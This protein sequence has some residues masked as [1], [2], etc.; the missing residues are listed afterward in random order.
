MSEIE[1]NGIRLYV[2]EHGSGAPILCIHGTGSSSLLW[3]EA[4]AELG[5]RGRAIVYDRR[6]FGR[7]ERPDPLVMDVHLHADDAAAL[8]DALGAGPAV[9]VGRSQGGEIAVDLALRYPER[10]RALALLEGG[11]L[12]LGEGLRRWVALLRERILV[13]AAADPETVGETMLREVVGDEGWEA[14]PAPVRDVFTAN[15]P[16]IVAEEL[17]GLLDVSAEQLGTIAHPTLIVGG[18]GSLPEFAEVTRL[19]AAAMPTATVAWVDGDH[20]IDPAHPAVLRFVDDVLQRESS[21][22]SLRSSSR[23]SASS[24]ASSSARP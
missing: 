6:G 2:E 22:T 5:K 4:G 24:P 10:V 15:G 19:T 14:L 9:V 3:S 11:G 18:E 7:S 21:S 16:A 8:I 12:T 17:G 13:A 20:L 23:H 1:V